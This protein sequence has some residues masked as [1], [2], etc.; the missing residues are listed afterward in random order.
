MGHPSKP[1]TPPYSRYRWLPLLLLTDAAAQTK[2]L[3]AWAPLRFTALQPH[4]TPSTGCRAVDLLNQAAT[5]DVVTQACHVS[6]PTSLQYPAALI[7]FG[8]GV[9]RP[10]GRLREERFF[11]LENATSQSS[12][13]RRSSAAAPSSVRCYACAHTF[14][15]KAR[16]GRTAPCRS[17]ASEGPNLDHLKAA[18]LFELWNI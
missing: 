4:P 11:N 16:G 2:H 12:G 1:S 13:L 15:N 3:D 14:G 18:P 17:N 6:T 9:M 5:S 10:R 8:F 7:A